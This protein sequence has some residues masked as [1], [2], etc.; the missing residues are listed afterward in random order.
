[1]GY[2]NKGH[3]NSLSCQ[4]PSVEEETAASM[5]MDKMKLDFD[6]ALQY[7][8]A[9]KLGVEVVVS[10]D[11]HFDKTDVERKEPRDFL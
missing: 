9:K 6:D 5:L 3:S 10:F 11:R 2:I 4:Y 1:M 7:F 8:V